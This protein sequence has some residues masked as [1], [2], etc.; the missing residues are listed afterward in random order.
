MGLTA[1]IPREQRLCNLI[2]VKLIF[3]ILKL[4]AGLVLHTEPRLE[5]ESVSVSF[6]N[7]GLVLIYLKF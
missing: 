5:A 4:L 3:K 1:S 2:I 7:S 6:V